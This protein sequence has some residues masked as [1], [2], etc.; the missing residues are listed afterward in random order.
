MRRARSSRVS[1]TNGKRCRSG[2]QGRGSM[3]ELMRT[4]TRVDMGNPIS[5][6]NGSGWMLSRFCEIILMSA[7]GRISPQKRRC[8][9][10]LITI[11]G[12]VRGIGASPFDLGNP[13]SENPFEMD[14]SGLLKCQKCS[15]KAG[16]FPLNFRSLFTVF[17]RFPRCRR[18]TL[19]V[20]STR[21]AACSGIRVGV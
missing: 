12:I 10:I 11:P 6:L 2:R 8:R 1:L 5:P 14:F 19:R 15:R 7:D 16:N 20:A 3:S 17:L 9:S 13:G 21:P 18:L 4:L